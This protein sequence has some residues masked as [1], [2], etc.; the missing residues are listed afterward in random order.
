MKSMQ[1]GFTLIELMIVVAIIG[2]LAGI[3]IPSYNNYIASSQATKMIGNKEAARKFIA[4]GFKKNVVEQTQG[5]P[6]N[7]LP[8]TFPQTGAL[9]LVAL[10]NNG[11]TAPEG[12]G[13]PFVIGAAVPATGTIGMAVNQ[14]TAG[15]WLNGDS[16]VL[17]S[18]LYQGVAADVLTLLF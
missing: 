8:L 7:G 2:I 17:S 4:S 14:G 15:Q 6:G 18:P 10:N 9:L 12:G 11:A 16:V 13:D 5:R 3:A 1:K